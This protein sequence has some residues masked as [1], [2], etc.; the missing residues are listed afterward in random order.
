MSEQTGSTLTITTVESGDKITV[1][2]SESTTV[3]D[4]INKTS[5]QLSL[6]FQLPANTKAKNVFIN[7]IAAYSDEW[8]QTL[9]IVTITTAVNGDK[10]TITN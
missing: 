7:R 6:E 1:T 8:S 5:C 10:I 9:D 4:V 2:G 3:I